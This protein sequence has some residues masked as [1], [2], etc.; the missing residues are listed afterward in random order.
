M[1]RA[2]IHVDMDAFYAAIEQRDRPDLRGKPV[3]VGADPRGRGVVSTASYEARRYGIHSAMPISEAYR[4]CPY[5]VYLPVDGAKYAR[6]SAGIMGILEEFSPVVEPLS[7]DEAFVDMTGTERLLWPP[8]EVVGRIK[9]RILAE[10]DLTASAGLAPNKFLAKIASD[11]EKPDGL[12]V[13]EPGREAEFLAPLPIRAMWGVGTVSE[14][15]FKGM[16]IET[17]GQLARTP[18]DLLTKRFGALGSHLWVLAH[19]IDN[20][21]VIPWREAKSIGAEETFSVDHRDLTLLEATLLAQ[22][23]RV[24]RECREA[25]V[26]GW[27]VTMKLRFSDFRTLTRS[28][29]LRCSTD[30]AGEIYEEARRLLGETHVGREIRL[31]GISVSNL[32]PATDPLQ[33]DLFAPRDRKERVAQA[34]DRLREKFGPEAIAR[35]TLIEDR[36]RRGVRR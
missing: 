9:Q 26:R 2:I 34:M 31:I 16:G 7:L 3:I 33:L 35:A 13:V 10:T 30:Q 36:G 25:R 19:G 23:E 20:R 4:R 22:A 27:T 6:V 15:D 17:V 32:V 28:Q 8:I 21:E 5:G 11:L 18:K 1:P 24:A 29:T 14:A 12:V